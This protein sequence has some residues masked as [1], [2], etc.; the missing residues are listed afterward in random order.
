[1]DFNPQG[2]REPRLASAS[3]IMLPEHGFQ[4]TRL[5]RA[6]TIDLMKDATTIGISIHK[7]LASLD[8]LLIDIVKCSD[9]SIHKALASLDQF[10]YI[11]FMQ[12]KISIHKALASLD[13]WIP[14]N[15]G[16]HHDFNPQGSR[17]PRRTDW[18]NQLDESQFQSTRLSRASTTERAEWYM[19][20]YISIHKALASLDIQPVS[21]KK[22]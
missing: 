4:S 18:F 15:E 3:E 19:R 10:E 2:S 8:H 5:S 11:R 6:S 17:E 14:D 22:R 9:I 12:K 21:S 7:A 20:E 16:H 1:M 13:R